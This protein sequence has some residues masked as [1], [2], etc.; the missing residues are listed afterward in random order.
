LPAAHQVKGFWVHDNVIVMQVGETGVV[1]NTSDPVFSTAW[2]NRFD[3]NT[4]TLGSAD[5]YY[6]WDPWYMTT[7]QWRAPSPGHALGQLERVPR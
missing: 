5:K 2:N 1:T 7:T 6:A 3:Y 4:Y